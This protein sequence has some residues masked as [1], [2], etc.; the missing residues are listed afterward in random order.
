M[1]DFDPDSYLAN[2]TQGQQEEQQAP[3]EQEGGQF[4]PDKYLASFDPDKYLASKQPQ[5]EG[6]ISSGVR[7]AGHAVIPGLAGLAAA[8][9]GAE[10]GAGIGTAILPGIGTGVGAFL[11]GAGAMI[12]ASLATEKAQDVAAKAVG[13]DDDTQRA[14]NSQEHPVASFVGGVG[15]SMAGMSPATN[16]AS[17]LAPIAQRALSGAAVGGFEAGSEKLRGEDFDPTKIAVSTAAGALMP[18]VNRLG[19]AVQTPANKWV[20]GR[21]NTVENPAASQAKVDVGLEQPQNSGGYEGAAVEAIPP[22]VR[23]SETIG[24]PQSAI[25]RDGGNDGSYAKKQPTAPNQSN[26]TFGDMD[27]ATMQALRQSTEAQALTNEHVME[28]VPQSGGQPQEQLPIPTGLEQAAAAPQP[29]APVDQAMT[30]MQGKKRPAKAQAA[31]DQSLKANPPT[32]VDTGLVEAAKEPENI[33]E[34]KTPNL[35]TEPE[36]EVTGTVSTDQALD[37]LTKRGETTEPK[38]QA[39]A[40]AGNYQK[41]KDRLFGHDVSYETE[42]GQIRR[43]YAKNEDG[44]QGK[45][46]WES[47]PMPGDYGHLLRTR[48]ADG[49]PLDVLNLAGHGELGGDKHFILDQKNP[50][51][52]KFDEHKIITNAK[53]KASALK[54][55]LDSYSDNAAPRVHDITETTEPVITT[56]AKGRGKS[57]QKPFGKPLVPVKEMKVVTE[58][59]KALKEK[60][61]DAD[62]ANLQMMP[63]EQQGV[64]AA[65]LLREVQTGK[66]SDIQTA[67]IRPEAPKVE[68]AEG[69]TARSVEDAERKGKALQDFRDVYDR[70]KPVEGETPEQTFKRAKA[71]QAEFEKLDQYPTKMGKKQEPAMFFKAARE[72]GKRFNTQTKAGREYSEGRVNDF[73]ATE[74]LLRGG[75]KEDVRQTNRIDADK[76][77]SRRSGE[78]A[79]ANAEPGRVFEH[80]AEDMEPNTKPEPVTDL[81]KLFKTDEHKELDLTKSDDLNKVKQDTRKIVENLLKTQDKPT[82]T[83]PPEGAAGEAFSLVKRKA[84]APLKGS[85]SSEVRRVDISTVDHTEL[86]RILEAA[87]KKKGLSSEELDKLDL[88]KQ[89]GSKPSDTRPE[90]ASLLDKRGLS[91]E[92]ALPPPSEPLPQDRGS[93]ERA[94]DKILKDFMSSTSG[95]FNHVR[96]ANDLRAK[97]KKIEGLLEKYIGAPLR[98]ATLHADS[99]LARSVATGESERAELVRALDQRS[100][101]WLTKSNKT[102]MLTYLKTIEQPGNKTTAELEAAMKA[103]GIPA[104]KVGWMAQEAKFHRELMDNVWEQDRKHGS[105]QEYVENYVSHIFEDEKGAAAHI[106]DRIAELNKRLGPTWYQK[107]RT[108]DLLEDALKAKFKLK[109]DNP[110]DLIYHRAAASIKSNMLVAT[111]RQLNNSGLAFPVKDAPGWVKGQWK[112]K[113]TLP[114]GQQWLISPDAE[115]LWVNAMEPAGL[116]EMKG[117]VGGLY[118]FWMNMKNI[119]VPV[120]L[121]FSAFHEV[122]EIGINLAE[123]FGRVMHLAKNDFTNRPLADATKS[124]L[125]NTWDAT[126]WTLTDPILALPIDKFPGVKAFAPKISSLFENFEG[127]RAM[128]NW[129]K[130]VEELDETE[131]LWKR[132]QQEGGFVP[133]Q[134][135]EERVMAKRQLAE[136]VANFT[137]DI[138]GKWTVAPVVWQA[139]R[140]AAE[141]IQAPMFKYQIP[142][143]KSVQYRRSVAAALDMDRTLINDGVKRGVVLRDIGKSIDNRFGEIFYKGLFWNKALKD[144]GTGSFLSLGWQLGQVREVAGAATDI[145]RT[146]GQLMGDRLSRLENAKFNHADKIAFVTS[147]V[148]TSM[149][150]AGAMSYALTGKKPDG[151]DYVFPKNGLDNADGT[152]QRLSPPFNTREPFQFIAHKEQHNSWA[153]GAMEYIWNKLVLSPIV[154]L[155]KNKDFYGKRMWDPDAPGYTKAFQALDAT[156]GNMFNPAAM[157]GA[158]RAGDLGGGIKEK[159][160]AYAGFNP[161]PKYIGV[162]PLQ[163]RIN[164]LF[165]EEGTADVKPYEYGPKT[166]LGHGLVQDTM[167]NFQGDKTQS[168]AR[169][170]ARTNLNNAIRSKDPEAVATARRALVTE[171]GVASRTAG[172]IDPKQDFQY[173]FSALPEPT[174]KRLVKEMTGQE[175]NDYVMMSKQHAMSSKRKAD[176]LKERSTSP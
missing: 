120:Q 136:A 75:G 96:F 158:K 159:G 115:N 142:A 109:F 85:K 176:L 62:A 133:E 122:H 137:A 154:E 47:P 128:E 174:Q 59:V 114:D 28:K 26:A 172:K 108:F 80:P 139:F 160:L 45:L 67:R 163:N 151:M 66:K 145:A 117:P 101:A 30:A 170:E 10:V 46:L 100:I 98:D 161:A 48:G 72:L 5:A 152:P 135:H 20:A 103:A 56:W 23:S 83:R 78:E 147:Y 3:Q 11:G 44:S 39:Q 134:S 43:K 16:A 8:P 70:H 27:P 169:A 84:E 63:R 102:E 37:R 15:G 157:S 71:A 88:T 104:E 155:A 6:A 94:A 116:N 52:G 93:L 79:I 166:G 69:V 124:L 92:D 150:L 110:I 132:L 168:E 89:K 105:K 162:T 68:G 125:G 76:N 38:S 153:G 34:N 60:G 90:E 9:Y 144:A 123:N 141:A 126:K 7:E 58:A 148:M 4:D 64:R 130:P 29:Q 61:R 65:Q 82:E 87:N 127:R 97:A 57:T 50:E 86:T 21:P 167:R 129:K 118:R 173:K 32:K 140:R 106:M 165:S 146:G 74:K 49:D 42:Q 131:R 31:I 2:V 1:A 81:S 121:M 143:M 73:I 36:P 175:F 138:N 53:D 156:A 119:F 91:E 19:E 164:Y 77:L 25:E 99:V 55:Y 51:T 41:A 24:N 12:A 13:L 149:M 54:G 35:R 22:V 14:I 18:G 171:G 40:E 95:S 33:A 111:A 112:L 113:R 17:K 107:E